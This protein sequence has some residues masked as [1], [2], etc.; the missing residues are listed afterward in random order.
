MRSARRRVLGWARPSPYSSWEGI[1]CTQH[2]RAAPKSNGGDGLSTPPRCAADRITLQF[3]GSRQPEWSQWSGAHSVMC[4]VR[5]NTRRRAPSTP[6]ATAGVDLCGKARNEGFVKFL[7]VCHLRLAK[8]QITGS[9]RTSRSF[10]K[11][12]YCIVD[13][14]GPIRLGLRIC[15]LGETADCRLVPLI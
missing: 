6:A 10:E 3:R 9:I 14:Q 2:V 8:T 13:A 4:C 12:I 1:P 5:P 11:N 15:G 7:Y